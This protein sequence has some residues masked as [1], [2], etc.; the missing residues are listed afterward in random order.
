[1]ELLAVQPKVE[2]HCFIKNPE[3]SALGRNMVHH[4]IGLIDELG[5]DAFT[6]KKLGERIQSNESSIYRYFESKHQ[7][8][9]YIA[10]HYWAW[11]EYR[12]VFETHNLAQPKHKLLQ[13]IRLVTQEVEDDAHTQHINERLLH[14]V[15]VKEFGKIWTQFNSGAKPSALTRIMERLTEMIEQAAPHYA[16]ASALATLLI[17]GGHF[18]TDG[19]QQANQPSAKTDFFI[20]LF[21]RSLHL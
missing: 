5:F 19:E 3:S 16:F 21:E 12:L 14:R 1:M 6:F 7:F 13:A 17:E 9:Q 10:Q 8:L 20:D 2:A 18:Q 11:L 4:G 15:M